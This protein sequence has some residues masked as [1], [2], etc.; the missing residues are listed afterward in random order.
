MMWALSK[1]KEKE[2]MSEQN[3]GVIELERGK[4]AD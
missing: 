4:Q 3:F 2:I 1:E